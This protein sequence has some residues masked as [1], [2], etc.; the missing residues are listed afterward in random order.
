MGLKAVQDWHCFFCT[1]PK[2]NS[3]AATSAPQPSPGQPSSTPLI[4]H[5]EPSL[6]LPVF[7]PT[8]PVAFPAEPSLKLLEQGDFMRAWGGIAGLQYALPATWHPW[9]AAGMNLTRFVEVCCC[10][11]EGGAMGHVIGCLLAVPGRAGEVAVCS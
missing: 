3:H 1:N 10:R 9:Q 4:Q 2:P 11:A 5:A 7:P 8:H 6:K